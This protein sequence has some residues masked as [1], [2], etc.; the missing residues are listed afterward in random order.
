MTEYQNKD[1][2]MYIRSPF[3]RYSLPMKMVMFCYVSD[4]TSDVSF[5]SLTVSLSLFLFM[6]IECKIL[7]RSD[8]I[9][10]LKILSTKRINSSTCVCT[11]YPFKD[12]FLVTVVKK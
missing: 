7:Y 1:L 11:V 10:E 9:C 8:C 3:L 5:I 4:L 6:V 12:L 2:S